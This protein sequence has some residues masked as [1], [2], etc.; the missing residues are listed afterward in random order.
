MRKDLSVVLTLSLS[1]S[2]IVD[3]VLLTNRFCASVQTWFSGSPG[4]GGCGSGSGYREFLAADDDNGNI[5]DGTPHM[6][7]IYEAFND[8]E[9]A[10]SSPSVKDSGCSGTPDAVPVVSVV[11]G[12]KRAVLSWGAVSGASNYQIYRTEG[13]KEC[14]QGKVLLGTTGGLS[15]TDEG[16]MNGR[17]YYYVVIP[18]GSSASCFGRASTCMTVV[19]SEGPNFFLSCD[20]EPVVF[21][22]DFP[23]S[24]ATK[25]CSVNVLGGL[26]GAISLSCDDSALPSGVTCSMSTQSIT[27]SGQSEASASVFIQSTNVNAVDDKLVVVTASFQAITRSSSISVSV[28]DE[29]GNGVCELDEYSDVC[30][31]DCG[32]QTLTTNTVDGSGAPGAMFKVKSIL[33]DIEVTTLSFFSGSANTDLVEVYTRPGEYSGNELTQDGWELVFSGNVD[34]LGR[35]TITNIGDLDTTVKI[36]VDGIQSFFITAA[37]NNVLYERGSSEGSLFVTDGILSFYEGVGLTSKFTGDSSNI[38]SP[39]IFRGVIG[40]DII[41][42]GTTAPTTQ[43][44]TSKP[45]T[46]SPSR[47][48]STSPSLRPT[49][50]NPSASPTTGKVRTRSVYGFASHAFSISISIHHTF[51][52][53]FLSSPQHHRQSSPQPLLLRS[54]SVLFDLGIH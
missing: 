7:A 54:K 29:C 11:S 26:T 53:C 31:T 28:V 3:C 35:N 14:G 10:C 33:R 8:Q 50:G 38:Y 49:T 16:L 40:Y 30:Q 6:R 39:R 24:T 52:F 34:M 17:E 18:K 36:P 21:T 43:S 47:Q 32:S 13:V 51:L 5:N 22:L 2:C 1:L 45:F 4:S 12:D 46:S 48:P 44:P 20:S 19:P 23:T 15:F 27:F 41:S 9:I 42:L 37:N 25:Q